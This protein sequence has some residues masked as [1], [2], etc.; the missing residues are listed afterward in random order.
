MRNVR[1]SI[2]YIIF[3]MEAEKLTG[4]EAIVRL[5]A[6]EIGAIALCLRA[7]PEQDELAKAFDALPARME[8]ADDVE[9]A[10]REAQRARAQEARERITAQRIMRE[11]AVKRFPRISHPDARN[12]HR[13]H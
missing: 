3:S 13:F 8:S 12:F 9:N 4:S 7:N 11:Q 5:S 1:S 6:E 10:E 2:W